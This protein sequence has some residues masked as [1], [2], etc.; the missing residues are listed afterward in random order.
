MLGIFD[1][2]TEDAVF[3]LDGCDGVHGV[4]AAEG[5]GGDFGETY[6]V[7]FALSFGGVN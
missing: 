2:G 7:D 3:H 6:V 5:G 1:F 4:R